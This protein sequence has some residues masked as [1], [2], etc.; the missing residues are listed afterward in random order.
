MEALELLERREMV[1]CQECLDSLEPQDVMD[2]LERRETEE[3]LVLLDRV[4]LQ[5]RLVCLETLELELLDLREIL[6]IWVHRVRQDHP[7]HV[8]SPEAGQS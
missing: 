5:E 6:E 2:T 1:V 7:A 8:N 4:D 3:I